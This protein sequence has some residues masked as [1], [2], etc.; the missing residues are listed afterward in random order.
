MS[1]RSRPK[2]TRPIPSQYVWNF[3]SQPDPNL[4]GRAPAHEEGHAWDGGSAVNYIFYCRGA[5]IVFDEWAETAGESE[6]RWEAL[7]AD[8]KATSHYDAAPS[9]YEMVINASAYGDGPIL[10]SH[11]ALLNGWDPYYFHALKAGLNLPEVDLNDG[12]GLGVTFS[13]NTIRTSSRTRAYA[14]EAYGW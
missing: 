12:S 3:T 10:L 1:Q 13:T 9:D 2:N 5:P 11:S 8:F 7:L 4:N 6:L 14:L